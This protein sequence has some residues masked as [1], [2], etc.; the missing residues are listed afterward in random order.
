M[1]GCIGCGHDGISYEVQSD[2]TVI[3]TV[4]RDGIPTKHTTT[5]NE[6][7]LN[8]ATLS[9]IALHQ[10]MRRRYKEAQR[11]RDEYDRA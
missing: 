9:G 10:A 6:L 1:S 7:G 8:Q 4:M 2:G 5:M 3:F 11:M